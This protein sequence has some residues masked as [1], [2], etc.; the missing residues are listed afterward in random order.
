MATIDF[1]ADLPLAVRE[2]Y[3]IKH[4]DPVKRTVMASGRSRSRRVFTSVVPTMADVTW[5]FGDYQALLFEAWF[6]YDLGDG[7][8]WFNADLRTPIGAIP[9]ECRF[10]DMY[11]GPMLAGDN[12]WIFKAQLEIIERPIT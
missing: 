11:E 10:A 9:Y 1:P 6:K 3:D 7:T 4:T 5:R 8:E 2:G 12:R